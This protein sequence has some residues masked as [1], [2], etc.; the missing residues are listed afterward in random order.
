MK[1]P[2]KIKGLEKI[3]VTKQRT[4]YWDD[5]SHST[6]QK[7][8][9]KVPEKEEALQV[10]QEKD[11]AASSLQPGQEKPHLPPTGANFTINDAN[12]FTVLQDLFN[13]NRV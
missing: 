5:K 6:E 3:W 12:K 1:K 11:S 2:R 4:Y 9:G 13:A 7:S 8:T 10:F